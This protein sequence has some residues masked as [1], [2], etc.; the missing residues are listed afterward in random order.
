MPAVSVVI[1]VYNGRE[2]VREAVA[3][4]LDGTFSDLEVL[5]MDDGSTD[6]SARIVES[7][8]DP[9]V[10]VERCG[11]N[12]GVSVVRN[13]AHKLCRGKYIVVMDADDI[14]TPDRIESQVRFMEANP[15]VDI[16]GAQLQSFGSASDRSHYPLRHEEIRATALFYCPMGHPTLIKRK[17]ALDRVGIG[18]NP[19]FR[20]AN[21]YEYYADAFAAGLTFAN[22]PDILL[23]HRVHGGSLTGSKEAVMKREAQGARSRLFTHAFPTLSISDMLAF[24]DL[25]ALQLKAR[26][27]VILELCGTVA[28]ITDAVGPGRGYDPMTFETLLV[29]FWMLAARGFI[30]QRICQRGDIEAV[31]IY[32]PRFAA[33]LRR[34]E[35]MITS[36]GAMLGE[37]LAAL[38][39]A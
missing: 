4:I 31:A 1:S 26:R 21:D 35:A 14:A 30:D 34:N 18:Y 12:R 24:S 3:S 11:V 15:H 23:R 9:R 32:D 33:F 20:I 36:E 7:M 28:R 17:A 25:A 37:L 39:D 13:E 38:R 19:G 8:G 22:L 2:F 10:R 5:V 27:R 6:D 29:R 16:C